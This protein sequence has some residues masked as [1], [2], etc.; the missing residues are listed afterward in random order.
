MA[1]VLDIVTRA[2]KKI[3]VVSRDETLEQFETD[4]GVAAYNMMVHGWK[5]ESVDFEHVD[6]SET[7]TFD[8][9]DEYQE[10]FVYLL[11]SRLSPDYLLPPAFDADRWFRDIQASKLQIDDV[12]FDRALDLTPSRRA[13]YGYTVSYD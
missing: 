12:E 2:Y 7:D 8:Y 3:G 1:T 4:E 13:R 11:A 5:L 9:G 6:Q 10:G